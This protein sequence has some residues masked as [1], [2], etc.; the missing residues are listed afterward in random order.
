MADFL[1][2]YE[3]K[4]RELDSVL[5]IKAELEKRG[6]TVE[7]SCPY[8]E[9]RIKHA[10]RRKAKVVVTSA[11]Y[12]DACLHFFVYAIAGFCRKVVNLQWE[13]S[14]TKRDESDPNLYH[15][16]KEYAKEA[17]HL[18]WGEETKNRLIK[19]GVDKD[20][21]IVLGPVQMDTL[22]PEFDG[23]YLNKNE[24]ALKYNIDATK[25]WVLFI[26]SFTFVNMTEQEYNFTL[27]CV[28]DWLNDFRRI[29]IQSKQEIT[30]WLE[31]AAKKYPKKI[32]IYRP[33]PSENGD[34]TL[35]ELEKKY[36]NFRMIKENSV[37]QW[38][39]C[40]DK[41]LTWYS[42]AAAE[43]FFSGKNCSILRPVAIP[44]EL[45]VT[46]YHSAHMLTN[47][48]DVFRNIEEKDGD[49]PLNMDALNRYY[50]IENTNPVYIRICDLLEQVYSTN[51]LDMPQKPISFTL[52][53]YLTRLR[54]RL[55]F[56][57][58]ETIAG[59]NLLILIGGQY[60]IKNHIAIMDRLRRDRAKNQATAE[61]LAHDFSKLQRV[62]N[63]VKFD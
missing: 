39:K 14:L 35:L 4:T 19:A 27:S 26:S 56:I 62:V 59:S 16:P 48:E 57:I 51:D 6:Y 9:D 3:L 52:R 33:H 8:D 13:Q 12:D 1:I 46:I 5:L 15:N 45:E 63:A 36:Q 17:V 7:L 42:T 25:D 11:L 54:N 18:C 58:K 53:L 28:G 31:L 40:S 55:A 22:R 60:L 49:F 24:L 61:E 47:V 37:K 32:F 50:Q 23:F 30:H 20:K 21:A 29:S 10:Q 41:I 38:I 2:N 43:V 44:D 34:E